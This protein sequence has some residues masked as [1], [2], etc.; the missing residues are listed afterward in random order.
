MKRM[1]TLLASTSLCLTLVACANMTNRDV[2]TITGGV[3][4]GALGNQIGGG[5]GRVLA[6]VGGTLIG[7]YIGGAVGQSMDDVD[8]MRMTQAF[9]T[10]RTNQATSW[11]NPDTGNTYTVTPTHTYTNPRGQACREYSTTAIIGGK[12]QQIYGT[13]CRTSDGSWKIVK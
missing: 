3:L 5:S 10:N 6:T 1:L 4:G 13:A 9:E 2:G 8:R 12:R 7:A 11:H